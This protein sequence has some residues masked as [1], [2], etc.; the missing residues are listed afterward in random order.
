MEIANRIKAS[1]NFIEA[2][3]QTLRRANLSNEEALSVM[4]IYPEWKPKLRYKVDEIVLWD[5]NLWRC[6][7]EHDSQDGWEP[8]SATASLW[9]VVTPDGAVPWQPS[10][11]YSKGSQVTHNGK[12]W[13]SLVDNNIWEPGAVGTETVWKEV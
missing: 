5:N 4:Y 12:T 8:S 9:E 6:K 7:K 2:T 11:T 1:A 13:E 10:T 3:S